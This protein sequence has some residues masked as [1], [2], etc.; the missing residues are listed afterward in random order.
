MSIQNTVSLTELPFYFCIWHIRVFV[1][2]HKLTWL[3]WSVSIPRPHA[4]EVTE[5]CKQAWCSEGP[6]LATVA[7]LFIRVSNVMWYL[8]FSLACAFSV[9]VCRLLANAIRLSATLPVHI[10]DS[11]SLVY[12]S[13]TIAFQ[14]HR[15]AMKIK[16][17]LHFTS[18]SIFQFISII[19]VL[20][21]RHLLGGNFHSSKFLSPLLWLSFSLGKFLLVLFRPPQKLYFSFLPISTV[22]SSFAVFTW[23]ASDKQ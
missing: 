21:H 11:F 17:T 9:L 22:W 2:G 10:K 20:V 16:T 14:I 5:E 4:R 7:W 19:I 18:I 6:L 23:L 8:K 3:S 13:W 1:S 12:P 15:L